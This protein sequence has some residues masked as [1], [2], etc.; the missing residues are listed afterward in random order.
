MARL[1]REFEKMVARIEEKLCP[2]GAI[3]TSPDKIKDRVTQNLREVDAS[4]R[5]TVGSV[6]ILITIECRDRTAVQ[7]ITWLEQ[8]KAKREGIAANQTIVVSKEGFTEGAKNYARHHGLILRQLS[9]VTDSFWLRSI[10]GLK[11]FSR[12][13]RCHMVSYNIGYYPQPEDEGMEQLSVTEEVVSAI[14][15]NKPFATNAAGEMITLEELYK[16]A[17]PELKEAVID[18]IDEI[19]GGFNSQES[20]EGHGEADAFFAPNDIAVETVRGAR[21]IR[22]IIFGIKYEVKNELLPPLKPMQYIDENGQVI[23]SFSATADA[24]GSMKVQ[25]KFGWDQH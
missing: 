2:L 10:Q 6:P 14:K 20:I 17:L 21:Y 9:E 1:G 24:E 16:E 8:I 3:V 23:D 4:I 12:D 5:Y 25:V 19:N 13:I 7:D 22:V 18:H 15:Q 11:V